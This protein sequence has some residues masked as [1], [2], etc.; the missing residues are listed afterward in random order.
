MPDIKV[1]WKGKFDL[2]QIIW[3][4][5][6]Y[7]EY[8]LDRKLDSKINRFWKQYVKNH[9]N[10]YDGNLLYLNN[11]Q[12]NND[13][14]ILNT[15]TIRYS[16]LIFMEKH[17]LRI[18]EGLGM[19]GVQCLIFDPKEDYILVGRRSKSLAY[20]PGAVT[21]PGGML[22]FDDLKQSPKLALLR[23]I[24]EEV[25]LELQH[26]VDL[27]AIITEFTG[28]SVTFLLTTK[29]KNLINHLKRIA[30]DEEEWENG[31]EWISI[32]DLKHMNHNSFIIFDGLQYYISKISKN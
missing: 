14:L 26:N 11:F 20:Y 5:T 32:N 29:C 19:I 18:D 27:I 8:K 13:Q 2:S 3:G 16:T 7:P 21:V 24:V 31:L 4:D 28:I 6:T 12:F 25:N 22:E 10:D 15:G 9:Q 1:L 30:S 23:E 17:K